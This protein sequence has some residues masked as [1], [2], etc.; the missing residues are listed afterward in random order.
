MLRKEGAKWCVYDS[1]GKKKL[2]EHSTKTKAMDQLVAIEI[3]KKK[4][5]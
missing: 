1:S 5:K 4:K 2:G 3:S